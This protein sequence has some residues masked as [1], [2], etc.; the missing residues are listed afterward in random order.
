MRV[1]VLVLNQ[2]VLIAHFN[3]ISR[4]V[5][6]C[7]QLQLQKSQYLQLGPNRGLYYGGSLPNVNQIGNATVEVTFQ[8]RC[9]FSVI[10]FT[11]QAG[12]G[13]FNQTG[14]CKVYSGHYCRMMYDL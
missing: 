12:E 6:S 3:Y 7:C 4:L 8:V 5:S 2:G 13:V 11:A 14:T 1:E 10:D 9:H